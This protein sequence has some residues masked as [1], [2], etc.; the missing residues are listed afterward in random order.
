MLM[1]MEHPL[2]VEKSEQRDQIG[3]EASSAE[4]W[5]YTDLIESS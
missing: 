4:V 3:K 2:R 1:A 5:L